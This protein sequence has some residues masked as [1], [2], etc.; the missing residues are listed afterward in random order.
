M[1]ASG[2]ANKKINSPTRIHEKAVSRKSKTPNEEETENWT[3]N[4]YHSSTS[5]Y[6]FA[7][8]E[9]DYTKNPK[10]K[11]INKVT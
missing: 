3:L 6:A 10:T 9:N 7:T 8:M 2:T 11:P 5:T 1:L 4:P